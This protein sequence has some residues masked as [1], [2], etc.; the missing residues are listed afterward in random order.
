MDIKKKKDKLHHN[1]D[2]HAKE[3]ISIWELNPK[4][5]GINTTIFFLVAQFILG[6]TQETT[7]L[8][9]FFQG[10][11]VAGVEPGTLSSN[12]RPDSIL[13]NW[14]TPSMVHYHFLLSSLF[15]SYFF[16]MKTSHFLYK[17]LHTVI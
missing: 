8:H 12:P 16:Q 2:K 11:P 3:N 10:F 17:Q 7:T 4:L 5:D 6:G 1:R 13:T 14:A 9:P 15:T